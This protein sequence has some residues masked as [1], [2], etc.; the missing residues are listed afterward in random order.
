MGDLAWFIWDIV[1]AWLSTL[2]GPIGAVLGLLSETSIPPGTMRYITWTVAG[3]FLIHS[4]WK[5]HLEIDGP[6][7]SMQ[8]ANIARTDYSKLNT[9]EKIAVRQAFLNHGYTDA[10]LAD[11]LESQGLPRSTDIYARINGKTSLLDRNS[12]TGAW[13][14][15]R[16]VEKHIKRQLRQRI[17]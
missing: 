15:R 10:Q 3:A 17:L 9:V 14:L 8:Q 16:P 7:L 5:V 13:F 6:T 4:I 1:I 12:T 11:F 2:S